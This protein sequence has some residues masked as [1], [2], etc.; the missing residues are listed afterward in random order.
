MFKNI[1][2]AHVYIEKNYGDAVQRKNMFCVNGT[3]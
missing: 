3:P 1:C 2:L